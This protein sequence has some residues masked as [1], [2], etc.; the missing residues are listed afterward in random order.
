MSIDEIIELAKEKGVKLSFLNTLIGAYRGK[1][2]DC[3]RGTSTLTEKETETITNYL[4][5]KEISLPPISDKDI[6]T[7][8]KINTLS[9]DNR[10]LVLDLID[11]LSN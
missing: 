6:D 5:N 2:T 7:I 9:A 4:L 1:L 3:K 10:K 8:D 11:K